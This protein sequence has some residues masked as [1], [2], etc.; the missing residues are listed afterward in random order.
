MA[1]VHRSAGIEYAPI[2]NLPITK[3]TLPDNLR[4]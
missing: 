4:L 1:I 2:R 3:V